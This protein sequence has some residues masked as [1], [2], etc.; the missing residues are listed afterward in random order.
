MHM[1]VLVS[2][3]PKEKLLLTW[4][5]RDTDTAL[6]LSPGA[7][8]K[9]YEGQVRFLGWNWVSS[10]QKASMENIMQAEIWTKRAW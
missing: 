7:E 2:Q 4:E 6:H 8:G 1:S 10:V 9:Q 3:V 5:Q